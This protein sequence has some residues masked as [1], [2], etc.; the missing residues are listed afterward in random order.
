[1]LFYLTAS[2]THKALEAM[3]KNPNTNRREAVEKM[4]TAA[5]GKLVDMYGTMAE[6]PGAMIIFDAD[7]IAAGA[8]T[9]VGASTD[10]LHNIKVQR[11]F[12]RDEVVAI[13]QKRVQIQASFK[14][15]GQ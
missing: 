4:V 1:M 13:R 15:P 5:G 3:A 11:L 12:T 7:P 10:G 2:Y 6:G 8:I 9:G 14:P